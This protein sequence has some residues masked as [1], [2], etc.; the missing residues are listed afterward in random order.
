MR[1]A[2]YSIVAAILFS[3]G[4][5]KAS[6]LPVIVQ[7]LEGSAITGGA[8]A[9]VDLNGFLGSNVTSV[10]RIRNIV[11]FRINEELPVYLGKPMTATL[12]YNLEITDAT[13]YTEHVNGLSLTISYDT[14]AGSTYDFRKS[15]VF[16]D[17]YIVNVIIDH[18][19]FSDPV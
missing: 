10:N 15:F 1:K 2:I 11:T 6:E 19:D 18:V 16:K 4:I 17:G 12:Y 3:T 7:K 14:A 5:A 8:T 9:L 13:G